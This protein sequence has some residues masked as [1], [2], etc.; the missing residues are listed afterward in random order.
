V[1]KAPKDFEKNACRLIASKCTL[2]AR[3][4]VSHSVDMKGESGK[5]LRE[6]IEKKIEKMQ[7]PPAKRKEKPLPL[8]DEVVKKKRGG[9]RARK[10]K[11]RYA[12]TEVH[13][14]ALRTPFG[15]TPTE[16]YGNT[17]KS[18]GVL[19]MEGSGQIRA[20]VRDDKG[21][22]IKKRLDKKMNVK[23]GTQT[24]ALPG[25]GFATSVYAMT[26]ALGLELPAGKPRQEEVKSSGIATSYFSH[27]S[28]FG[29]IKKEEQK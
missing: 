1:K 29:L 27:T 25:G 8:P 2:A 21:M 5:R 9:E 14:R 24:V 28:G 26:P 18:L 13:K 3:I 22:K 4:D 19:G 16:E 7:E 6:E 23:T 12:I 17:L 15:T 10:M 20:N 11:Q